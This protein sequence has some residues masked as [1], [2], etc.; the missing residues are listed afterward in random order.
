MTFFVIYSILKTAAKF[1]GRVKRRKSFGEVFTVEIVEHVSK[2]N[3][4][5]ADDFFGYYTE[6]VRN[7]MLPYQWETLNDRISDAEPSHAVKN[8]RIAAGL[9]EGDFRGFVFQDSDVAK[10]LEAV[11]HSLMTHPDP[12]LER[13]ADDVI[14][15]LEKAQCPD[16]YLDTYFIINKN[17]KRWSNLCEC[18]E[19]Y[20]AGHLIEAAVAYYEA[21]GKDKLL[22]I[23]CRFADLIDSVFGPEEGKI[24]GYPGHQEIELA[25]VKLY[26]ATGNPRYLRLSSFFINERG[27]EPN[28]FLYEW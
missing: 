4:T 1:Y 25:L 20:C 24:K 11:G 14:D 9:E 12:E 21:T 17:E 6:L 8:F 23:A 18:H 10:W 26:K 19:L 2:K 13:T 7:T 22:K 27:K 5:I 16:G 15:L 3:V 28:Y